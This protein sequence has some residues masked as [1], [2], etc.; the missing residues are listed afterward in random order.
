M[1]TSS[2]GTPT[3][4]SRSPQF[5]AL[6][7]ALLHVPR[8]LVH[9]STRPLSTVLVHLS[10]FHFPLSTFHF[11]I[12]TFHCP[13]APARGNLLCLR[14]SLSSRS[15]PLVQPGE[16]RG[17]ERGGARPGGRAGGRGGG[18]DA[19]GR[20]AGRRAVGVPRR[21][22]RDDRHGRVRVPPCEGLRV[23]AAT[24]GYIWLHLVTSGYSWLHLVTSG[25]A[26]MSVTSV[27]SVTSARRRRAM[28]SLSRRTS[29]QM[30]STLVGAAGLE[31]A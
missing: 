26:V 27:T 20:S 10:T 9:P 3:R 19:V 22:A 12:S 2:D 13:R 15:Q 1:S 8:I 16:R 31:P 21:S 30:D 5:L 23:T 17:V 4:A 18:A 28:G 29:F 24:S 14:A 11:P 25:S 7:A 6:A